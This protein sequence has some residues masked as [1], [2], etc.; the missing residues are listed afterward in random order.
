[1]KEQHKLSEKF[2]HRLSSILSFI[3]IHFLSFAPKKEL[4]LI[5]VTESAVTFLSLPLQFSVI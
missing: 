2:W 5:V 3:D 1:M 4:I